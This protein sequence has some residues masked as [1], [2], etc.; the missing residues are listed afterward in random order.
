MDYLMR[1]LHENGLRNTPI[2]RK[3]LTFIIERKYAVSHAELEETFNGNADRV[4]LYRA[5]QTLEQKAILHKILDREGIARYAMCQDSCS[6]HRHNDLHFHCNSCKNVFCIPI[7][8]YPVVTLPKDFE[9]SNIQL[10][11]EGICDKCGQSAE[12][13]AN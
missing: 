13:E 11:A 8:D 3:V 7:D 12:L 9:L 2:R 10:N 5:L 1:L 6:A 4:T